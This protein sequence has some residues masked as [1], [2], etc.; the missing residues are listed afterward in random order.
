M[1]VEDDREENGK[2]SFYLELRDLRKGVGLTPVKLRDD[3]PRVLEALQRRAGRALSPIQAVKELE[4]AIT[5]LP[6]TQNRAAMINVLAIGNKKPG[7]MTDRREDWAQLQEGRRGDAVEKWE[8]RAF[9]EL[10]LTLE[11]YLERGPSSIEVV[12]ARLHYTFNRRRVAL[13]YFEATVKALHDNPRTSLVYPDRGMSLEVIQGGQLIPGP[14]KGI[15][16]WS[17]LQMDGLAKGEEGY[18]RLALDVAGEP[19]RTA[20][21]YLGAKM[22]LR[23]TLSFMENYWPDKLFIHTTIRDHGTTWQAHRQ[24][25]VDPDE[26]DTL[27]PPEEWGSFL[28]DPDYRIRDVDFYTYPYYR[29]EWPD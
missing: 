14:G 11:P 24:V 22:P 10:A 29:W 23:M 12:D 26:P 28:P 6:D 27:P 15:A 5:E 20:S 7:W 18:V 9:K 25:F 21:I 4:D 3:A 2:E 8:N 1:S 19:T 16:H 13:A 17:Q